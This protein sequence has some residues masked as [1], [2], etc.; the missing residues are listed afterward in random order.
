MVHKAYRYRLYPN[1]KQRDILARTFGCVRFVYNFFLT[2]RKQEY[3][4]YYTTVTYNRCSEELTKLKREPDFNWLND[5]DSTALQSALDTLNIAFKNMFEGRSGYPKYKSRKEHRDSYTSKN[6]NNSIAVTDKAVKLPK[7]GFVRAKVS[8]PS[9]GRIINATVSREPSGKYYVSVLCECDDPV[10]YTG[11]IA[12]GLDLGLRDFAVLSDNLEHIPNPEPLAKLLAHLK[13]EQRALSRKSKGSHRY[14]V[15]RIK[16][17]KLHERIRNIRNDFQQK[18]STEL[19]RKYSLIG[20]EDLNVKQLLADGRTDE[21]RRIS[22]SGW[23]A[24]DRMLEYK[25]AWHGRRVVKVNRY[26]P[27]S[28]IC[29]NCGYQHHPVKEKRL[30]VWSCPGCGA[31]HQRDENAALNIMSEALRLAGAT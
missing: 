31:V 16:V 14:E 10:P 21:A 27:S 9:E 7:L 29:H 3:Q 5:V 11:G 4:L 15:Q 6:N 17:A 30:P 24:F 20:I 22:D 23:A 1:K 18:H 19:I 12:V 2:M 8:R 28:Q 25:A 13:Q 26:Y